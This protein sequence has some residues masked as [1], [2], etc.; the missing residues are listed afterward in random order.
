MA[1]SKELDVGEMYEVSAAIPFGLSMEEKT[2]I[3][4]KMNKELKTLFV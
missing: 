1:A 2:D 4:K 3:S